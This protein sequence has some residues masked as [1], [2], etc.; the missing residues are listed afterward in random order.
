MQTFDTDL[1]KLYQS[2]R[3]SR[4]EALKN[5]DSENNL[6]L[7]IGFDGEGNSKPDNSSLDFGDD[8]NFGTTGSL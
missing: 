5:A 6:S 1:Y 7:K 3:I 4:E 8:L 2:G